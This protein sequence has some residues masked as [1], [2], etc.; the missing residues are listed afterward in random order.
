MRATATRCW[1]FAVPS[2]TARSIRY[3][4]AINSDYE[5]RKNGRMLLLTF[6]H[7][8]AIKI[9]ITDCQHITYSFRK[10]PKSQKIVWMTVLWLTYR[11]S[12]Q[13]VSDPSPQTLRNA[14]GNRGWSSHFNASECDSERAVEGCLVLIAQQFPPIGEGGDGQR[15]R[16]PRSSCVGSQFQRHTLFSV[17]VSR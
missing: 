2:I 1:R 10:K 3:L 7:L 8:M 5:K 4:R 11:S 9:G 12:L 13:N 6:R 14:V 15:P 16:G 17:T